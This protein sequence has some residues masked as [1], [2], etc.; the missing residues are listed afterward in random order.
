MHGTSRDGPRDCE[1]I[2]EGGQQQDVKPGKLPVL[3][4]RFSDMSTP[5]CP[6]PRVGP[7]EPAAYPIDHTR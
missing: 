3:E 2:G 4:P 1:T 5:S 7:H 6:S